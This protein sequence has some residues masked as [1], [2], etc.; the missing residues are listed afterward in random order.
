M[1]IELE[2]SKPKL[3]DMRTME[4]IKSKLRKHANTRDIF[5]F[6]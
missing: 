6:W 4:L 5:L 1:Q 2:N 3:I